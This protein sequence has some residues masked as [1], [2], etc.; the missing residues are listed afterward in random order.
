[1]ISCMEILLAIPYIVNYQIKDVTE[2]QKN[3]LETELSKR[4]EYIITS[5]EFSFIEKCK[6]LK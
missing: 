4:E 2:E 5:S 3:C 1:M 6:D